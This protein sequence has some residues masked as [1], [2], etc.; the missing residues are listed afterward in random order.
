MDVENQLS[1]VA[2]AL[3]VGL[4]IGLERCWRTREETPGSRTAGIWTFAIS[5]LLG[6]IV[7]AIAES[8]DGTLNVAGAIVLGTGFVTDA[9]VIATYCQQ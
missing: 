5:G 6:W 9:A 8:P 2:L 7:G 3:G 1:R 4:L